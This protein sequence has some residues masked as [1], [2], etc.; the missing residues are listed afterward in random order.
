MR[1]HTFYAHLRD[2]ADLDVGDKVQAGQ[3]I[4]Y[5][6]STGNSTGPHLHYELRTG[7]GDDYVNTTYGFTRGRSNPE[8]ILHSYGV[9]PDSIGAGLRSL[10]AAAGE[11][12]TDE[13][14]F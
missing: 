2:I 12:E 9:R 11:P 8:S 10:Q 4:G 3:T 14:P 6:G 7:H 5:V 1:L 13:V